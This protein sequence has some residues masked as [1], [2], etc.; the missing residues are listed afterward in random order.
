MNS[1]IAVYAFIL[2]VI[3]GLVAGGHYLAQED[4]RKEHIAHTKGGDYDIGVVY[5]MPFWPVYVAKCFFE[6]HT[7]HSDA[8][9]PEDDL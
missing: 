3:I 7:R 4:K 8:T 2:Y 6:N 9:K 5:V 1:R